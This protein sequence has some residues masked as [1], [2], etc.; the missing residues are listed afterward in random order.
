[1]R[2]TTARACL[3]TGLAA[4]ATL[5]ISGTAVSY[6]G[7]RQAGTVTVKGTAGNKFDPADIQA[8]LDAKGE[9]TIDFVSEGA[10]HTLQSDD[11]KALNSGNVN[12]GET[13]TITFAA[14]PGTY[15]VY[16]LYH[17]SLGMTGTLTVAAAGSGGSATPT[18]AA[19]TEAPASETPAAT[20]TAAVV[21]PSA[22]A[23]EEDA[24]GI[25]GNKELADLDTER[26]AQHGAV[27]GFRFFTMVA[28]AFLVVLSAGVLFSTRPRRSGT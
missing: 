1:M 2:S 9:V 20:A 21:E 6:A 8:T 24:P 27:S 25:A 10:P 4:F 11:L 26:A 14:K 18:A 17:K 13:K 22:S 3:A 5:V 12:A 23:S 28:V 16:C 19:T 15:S 7:V